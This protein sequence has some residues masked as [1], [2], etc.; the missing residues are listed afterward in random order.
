MVTLLVTAIL[1][2]L[3]S[4]VGAQ[5]EDTRTPSVVVR[6]GDTL[7]SISERRLGTGA[8]PQRIMNGAEKIHALNRARIG[9]DPNLILVGQELLVP[10]AMSEPPAG[11][12]ATV[13]ARKAAPLRGPAGKEAPRR[14]PRQGAIP[15]S[16]ISLEEL[17]RMLGAATSPQEG[18]SARG[19]R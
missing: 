17:A 10:P 11:V 8:T 2:L 12:G 15:R 9:A 3:P 19:G 1:A 14:A 13:S 18:V 6:P 16:G 5:T 7:W 4:A